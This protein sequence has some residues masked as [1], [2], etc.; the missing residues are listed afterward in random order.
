[1]KIFKCL[2]NLTKSVVWES[3]KTKERG[4]PQRRVA[5]HFLIGAWEREG[6]RM[7]PSSMFPWLHPW[8]G[9]TG[10]IKN[11]LKIVDVKFP[12]SLFRCFLFLFLLPFSNSIHDFFSFFPFTLYAHPLFAEIPLFFR[13]S[14]SRSIAISFSLILSM[15]RSFPSHFWFSRC[16]VKLFCIKSSREEESPPHPISFTSSTQLMTLFYPPLFWKTW[17]KLLQINSTGDEKNWS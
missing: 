2:T 3:R 5:V 14:L 10:R 4:F 11:Y 9:K 7:K 16:I 17:S 12:S 8:V 1:M 6:E 15:R 13:I